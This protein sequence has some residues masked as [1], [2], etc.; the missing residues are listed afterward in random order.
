MDSVEALV[1]VREVTARGKGPRRHEIP[2]KWLAERA[3]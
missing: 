2:N 1:P 3:S